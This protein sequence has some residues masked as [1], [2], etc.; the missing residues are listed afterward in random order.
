[1]KIV[2]LIKVLQH[3]SDSSGENSQIFLAIDA[4][5]AKETNTKIFQDENIFVNECIEKDRTDIYLQ[6]FPY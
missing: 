6:N 2:D 3:I 4:S 5:Q 1:M